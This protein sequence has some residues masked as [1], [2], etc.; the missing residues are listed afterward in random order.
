M[1]LTIALLA[2]AL[3]SVFA[4]DFS[5]AVDKGTYSSLLQLINETNAEALIDATAPLSKFDKIAS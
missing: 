4:A 1:K 2:S 3:G 5:P